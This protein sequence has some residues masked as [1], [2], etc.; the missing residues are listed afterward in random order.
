MVIN[1]DDDK[2][3]TLIKE[4]VDA[5]DTPLDARIHQV[6]L[7]PQTIKEAEDI[8]DK[9]WRDYPCFKSREDAAYFSMLPLS[10][11]DSVAVL[12]RATELENEKCQEA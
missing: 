1:M 2:K 10:R 11:Q 8:A 7:P 6:A 9:L 3:H 4:E 5:F 12:V